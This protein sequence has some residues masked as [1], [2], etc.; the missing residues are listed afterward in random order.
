[1]KSHMSFK[2]LTACM[3]ATVLALAGCS[4]GGGNS[5]AAASTST[6]KA[7]RSAKADTS[8]DD[9]I[10]LAYVG[11]A[12]CLASTDVVAAVLEKAGYHVKTV[13]VTGAM[14][15][16]D[17]ASGN[18]DGMVC[19]WL[20]TTHKAYYA[21]TKDRLVNLGPNMKG[22][23]IGLVVPEYVKIDSI[24]DLAKDD[25]AKKFDNRIVGTGPGAGEMGVTRKAIKAYG[26]PEKLIVGSGATM[27]AALGHAIRQKKPIVVTG[28]TP[29]WMWAR[30]DLK[31]LKDPKGIYG[32]PE[33]IDTLVRKG[34]KK[35]MPEAYAILD[36]FHWT[37]KEMGSV[38]AADRK[39]GSD[40]KADARKWVKSHPQDV[41]SWMAE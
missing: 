23:K 21:K 4:G 25:V 37:S 26:L 33:N 3:A 39:D 41:S 36:N 11:W 19:A 18:V 27:T 10:K 5:Q 31:Y 14:L 22:A 12:S 9:T 34:L 17:L 29:H 2:V 6:A 20:P 1:M 7:S 8:A 15:Y 35:D 13:S 30:W 28:W 40:P 38:M 16:E 24:A 32:E